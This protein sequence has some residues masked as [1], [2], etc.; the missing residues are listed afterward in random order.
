MTEDKLNYI[1][2]E[3]WRSDFNKALLITAT[4]SSFLAM[5][6]SWITPVI[7]I[8]WIIVLFRSYELKKEY[9]NKWYLLL[10]L[11]IA[12]IWNQ[13]DTYFGFAIVVLM[14]ALFVPEDKWNIL[15]RG[16]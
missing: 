13:F 15:A 2:K 5:I 4:I 8:L 6:W 11:V 14:L 3:F 1:F 16:K 10:F 7:M 9:P 12:I